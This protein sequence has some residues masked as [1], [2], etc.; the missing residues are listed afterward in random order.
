MS[1]D[2]FISLLHEVLVKK[3]NATGNDIKIRK[4]IR[5]RFWS[6][7]FLIEFN[8]LSINVGKNGVMY[9]FPEYNT[10]GEEPVCTI[11]E[12]LEG[13]VKQNKISLLELEWFILEAM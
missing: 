9:S 11:K 12:F 8:E 10:E 4:K 2:N 7:V 6:T 3:A 5:D 13:E 1:I